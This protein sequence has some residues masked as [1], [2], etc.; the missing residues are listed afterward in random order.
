M[1][2]IILIFILAYASSLFGQNTD[3]DI[4]TE[5]VLKQ[6][7]K[8]ELIQIYSRIVGQLSELDSDNNFY[9]KQ[10]SNIFFPENIILIDS[11]SKL[12]QYERTLELSESKLK[13]YFEFQNY[14]D[15][16]NKKYCFNELIK[17]IKMNKDENI[18][19]IDFKSDLIGKTWKF[20]PSIEQFNPDWAEGEITGYKYED[21]I[22]S[23][24]FLN[25]DMCEVYFRENKTKNDKYYYIS[26][27]LNKNSEKP[28]TGYYKLFKLSENHYIMKL[29][30]V[31][32]PYDTEKSTIYLKTTKDGV[33]YQNNFF[34]RLKK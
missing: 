8:D 23:V 25:E 9:V 11:L 32:G 30:A 1:N 33:Y 20:C 17:L 29:D 18:S 5:D 24:K 27:S 4:F 16:I 10:Q 6:F 22:H 15:I 26:W 2:K 31:F 19:L 12:K 14:S 21:D 34:G 13:K 28:K 3:K 7:K